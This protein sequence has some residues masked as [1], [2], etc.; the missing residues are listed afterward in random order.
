MAK[1]KHEQIDYA[2]LQIVA[3][4]FTGALAGTVT[5]AL[6]GVAVIVTADAVDLATTTALA[7]ELKAKVNEIIAVLD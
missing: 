4:E 2:G 3:D 7:N 1:P 5:G 6:T